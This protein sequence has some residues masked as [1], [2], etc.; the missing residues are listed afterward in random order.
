MKSKLLFLLM[1]FFCAVA[2]GQ[3]KLVKG[4][5]GIS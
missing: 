5:G 2:W 3:N 1:F 4:K